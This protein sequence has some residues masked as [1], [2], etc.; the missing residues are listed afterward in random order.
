MLTVVIAL[1]I[2]WIAIAAI[3]SGDA[4]L[5]WLII[6]I[7]DRFHKSAQSRQNARVAGRKFRMRKRIP[8]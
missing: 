5:G 3:P 2:A 8:A 6:A 7:A 4:A 1:V